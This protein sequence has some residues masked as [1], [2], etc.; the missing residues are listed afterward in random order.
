MFLLPAAAIMTGAA[1]AVFALP[2]AAWV[3]GALTGLQ[4]AVVGLLGAALWRLARSEA[5]TLLLTVVLLA[6]FGAGLFINAAIVVAAGGVIGIAV[7]RIK[8]HA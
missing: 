7:D 8:R 6:A 2:D 4:V 3:R 1:A 5:G